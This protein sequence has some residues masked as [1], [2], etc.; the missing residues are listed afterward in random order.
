[1][2]YDL[3]K[4]RSS[5]LA[6]FDVNTLPHSSSVRRPAILQRPSRVSL[7]KAFPS[8]SHRDAPCN[9][10]GILHLCFSVLFLDGWLSSGRQALSFL[11]RK[12]F[13][14]NWT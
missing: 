14:S 2:C 5:Y 10:R 8:A 11:Y 4:L 13:L 7:H 3:S 1:M 6:A 12:A 9:A